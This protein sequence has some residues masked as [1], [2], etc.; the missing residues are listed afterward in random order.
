MR[1]DLQSNSRPG[2]PDAA[3]EV[4]LPTREA[5]CSYMMIYARYGRHERFRGRK[6]DSQHGQGPTAVENGS[7]WSL[8][9]LADTLS[10]ARSSVHTART[11]LRWLFVASGIDIGQQTMSFLWIKV[12]RSRSIRAEQ[13]LL[14][15]GHPLMWGSFAAALV[16]SPVSSYPTNCVGRGPFPQVSWPPGGECTIKGMAAVLDGG[17]LLLSRFNVPRTPPR[18]SAQKSTINFTYSVIDVMA[19]QLDKRSPETSTTSDPDSELEDLEVWIHKVLDPDDNNSLDGERRVPVRFPEDVLSK[20]ETHAQ[21]NGRFVEAL[22]RIRQHL[23][24]LDDRGR[25]CWE[26]LVERGIKINGED[27]LRREW[28]G[29]GDGTLKLS[30]YRPDEHRFVVLE[31]WY[32]TFSPQ[33]NVLPLQSADE[34]EC[35][36]STRLVECQDIGLR[37]EKSDSQNIGTIMNRK[38]GSQSHH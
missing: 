21:R 5:T 6:G 3:G 35:E 7:D 8:K 27:I 25:L 2:A 19:R 14:P 23:V 33:S 28:Y 37:R 22:K 1:N 36:P 32:W 26:L 38:Q 4:Y 20:L 24:G 11:V 18:I 30:H 12:L 17:S 31:Y 15:A 29:M 16:R 34:I 13:C 9:L 10:Q